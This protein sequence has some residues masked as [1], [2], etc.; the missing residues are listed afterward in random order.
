M[1]V[2]S[3]DE[4]ES[5]SETSETLENGN[6]T[7]KM[8][9]HEKDKINKDK[10]NEPVKS[11]ETPAISSIELTK[12]IGNKEVK[13]TT[14]KDMLRAQRDANALKTSSSHINKRSKSTSSTTSDDS[15]STD[16]DTSDSSSDAN[17][18]RHH[19]DEEDVFDQV[20]QNNKPPENK[21]NENAT[22]SNVLNKIQVNGTAMS[23]NIPQEADVQFLDTLNA[24]SRELINK[25]V[26][27]AK[28][29]GESAF[30]PVSAVE[31]LNEYV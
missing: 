2:S 13:T 14:V 10:K 16:S 3:G 26:D 18:S 29:V 1:S 5:L 12:E 31:L 4:S 8:K 20:V 9:L 7:K 28:N 23:D 27:S 24:Y 15:S 11:L 17:P 19:S 6:V 21:T 22:A 30:Q 25:F